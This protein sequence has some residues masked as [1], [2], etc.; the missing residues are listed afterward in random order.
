MEFS[1]K[2]DFVSPPLYIYSLIYLYQY[3]LMD[4]YFIL[5]II[6]QYYINF[7]VIHIAPY[8]GALS[9][10]RVPLPCPHLSIFL[11]TS[12][13]FWHHETSRVHLVHSLPQS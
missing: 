13:T 10:S 11:S 12:L 8:L 4:N 5:Q 6:V 2:E 9:G 7:F 3:G 1:I